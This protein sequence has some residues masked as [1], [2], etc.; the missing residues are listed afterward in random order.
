MTLLIKNKA[1]WELIS[2]QKQAQINKDHIRKNRHRF[3]HGYK[4]GYNVMLNN[5]AALKYETPYMGTF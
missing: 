1:D 3:D 5:H 2:Q 4:V